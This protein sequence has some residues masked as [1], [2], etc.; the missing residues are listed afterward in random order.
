MIFKY[1]FCKMNHI[2][3]YLFY[4]FFIILGCSPNV[5]DFS[6]ITIVDDV[7]YYKRDMSKVTG[8]VIKHHNDGTLEQEFESI[9]GHKDKVERYWHKNG[10]LSDEINWSNNAKNGVEKSWYKNGQLKDEI[11]WNGG[12][13]NGFKRHWHDNGQLAWESSFINGKQ[14][15][16]YR[17][18]RRGGMLCTEWTYKDGKS[19]DRK[20]WGPNGE[21]Y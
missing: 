19:I 7:C 13:K 14:D 17:E 16:V 12:L 20:S 3:H 6:E 8:K 11:H 18:W 9:S 5:I 1:Y 15:G 21:E 4:F 2:R 10:Q